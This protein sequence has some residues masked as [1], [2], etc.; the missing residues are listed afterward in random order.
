M[1]KRRRSDDGDEEIEVE[2]QEALGRLEQQAADDDTPAEYVVMGDGQFL[3][4]KP[5]PDGTL[6]SITKGQGRALMTAGMNLKEVTGDWSP[7]PP[8]EPLP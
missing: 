7:P 6:L 4:N 5:V 8:E 3:D 1:A 2:E